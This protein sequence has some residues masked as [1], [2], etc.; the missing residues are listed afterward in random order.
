[1][2]LAKCVSCRITR[3]SR[4]SA[5][6]CGAVER[7]AGNLDRRLK[8]DVARPGLKAGDAF[9]LIF[10]EVGILELET[11]HEQAKTDRKA[12]RHVAFGTW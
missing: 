1:M 9:Q 3:R 10:G 8:E 7:E 5:A 6:A 11:D 2:L 4:Y 12:A